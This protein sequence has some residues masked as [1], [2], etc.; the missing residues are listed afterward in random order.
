MSFDE[1][2]F[3]F[4][5][6]APD[7]T[8][9]SFYLLVGDNAYGYSTAWTNFSL[10]V[11]GDIDT[12]S[13]NLDIGS[14]YTI[15]ATNLGLITPS[16]TD[17]DFAILNRYGQILGFSTDYGTYSGITFTA[18]DSRYYIQTFTG[19][20]GHYG[21]RL[22][23]NSITEVNG[24]GETIN[25]GTI[26]TAAL[27]YGSDVDL[28]YFSGVAGQTYQIEIASTV[29]DLF[30]DLEFGELAVGNI[31]SPYAGV[32]IYRSILWPLLST[33]II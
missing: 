3:G 14:S 23:N 17:V 1:A 8:S 16:V 7:T 27:D 13:M 20:V 18:A 21:M 26:I 5:A 24:I 9:T 22:G 30:L 11:Y 19:S 4:V 32:S 31:V 25:A 15:V 28:Y 29:P 33:H 10:G 6:D 2:R 12:Y